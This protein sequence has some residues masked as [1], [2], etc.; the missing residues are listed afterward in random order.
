MQ[1]FLAAIG[2]GTLLQRH[3]G[4]ADPRV[5]DAAKGALLNMGMLD[6]GGVACTL[7]NLERMDLATQQAAGG[8]GG[9]GDSGGAGGG[10]GGGGGGGPRF[11]VFL[12]HKRTD[13]KDFARAMYNLLMLRGFTTFLDFEYRWGVGS[14]K[15]TRGYHPQA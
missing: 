9:S 3:V 2:I 12:S 1:R 8:G 14:Q 7:S 10:G 11:D 4:H 15:Q 6:G 5:A 13:A